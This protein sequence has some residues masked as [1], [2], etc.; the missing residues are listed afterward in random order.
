MAVTSEDVVC[1]V[2]CGTGR[3]VCFFSTTGVKSSIGVEIVPQIADAARRN[4]AVVRRRRAEVQIVTA[5]AATYTFDGVTRFILFNPFGA[6]TLSSVMT[7]IRHS[8]T[9]HPRTA[10]VYYFN[11]VHEALLQTE[12]AWMVAA[13]QL[14]VVTGYGHR[15]AV[16]RIGE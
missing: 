6:K 3:I 5:D 9:A 10:F 8:V 2:G 11:P 12:S 1:D 16:Y 15:V 7:N 13:P 4:A 14:D